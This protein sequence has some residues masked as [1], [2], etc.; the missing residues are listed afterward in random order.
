MRQRREPIGVILAGGLGR[1][2]GGA[3]AIVKLGGKP[4]ITYPLDAV[5]MALGDVA[6]IAKADTE[7]PN[8]PGVPVWIEPATPRHP[9]VGITHALALAGGRAVLVCAA[10]LP[11]VTPALVDRIAHL[12]PAGAPAVVATR[13][14]TMQPLLACYQPRAAKLLGAPAADTDLPLQEAVA[15]ICPRLCEVE[16]PEALFNVN[17]PDDLLQAAGMLDRRR[18]VRATK[19]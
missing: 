9:L 6:I 4:L 19:R 15:A 1:R 11:F 16:D 10:D 13:D 3:K 12:D 5:A 17:A 7:L 14:R 8:L 2:I 18:R